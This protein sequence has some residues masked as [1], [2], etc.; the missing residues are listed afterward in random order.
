M[1]L[2]DRS[3]S[4]VEDNQFEDAPAWDCDP[5]DND[6]RWN[7]ARYVLMHPT[8]GVVKPLEDKVRFGQ[9]L[10]SAH[11]NEDCPDLAGVVSPA[12]N[13]H[14]EMLAEF[15]CNDTYNDT[16]T[17]EALEATVAD[18]AAF[19]EPGPKVIVLATDG[20]PDSCE[21]YD[22]DNSDFWDELGIENQAEADQIGD[23]IKQSVVDQA[24][25]AHELGIT[26]HVIHIAEQN[27]DLWA[28]VQEVAEAGGGEAYDAYSVTELKDAF[29]NIVDG[30]R[31]CKIDLDGSIEEGKESSGTVTL[32]G[33]AL[34]LDDPNG[35]RVTNESQIEL[36]GEACE[37]I[38]AGEHDLD[39]KFPCGTFVPILK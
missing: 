10:Y 21:Y 3:G 13:N 32:D 14:D 9:V 2:V 15:E 22:W 30:S 37:T 26:V 18:L 8:E 27:P 24:T 36:L 4:M 11:E 31:N 1:L 20:E 39:I 34:E 29:Q 28:H 5:D 25:A 12:L 17:K 16:P 19:D 6:W 35:W 38:K 33:E 23:E 7:V